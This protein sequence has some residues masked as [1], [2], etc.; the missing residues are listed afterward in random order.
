M[1]PIVD[2]MRSTYEIALPILLG[3]VIW[4]LQQQRNEISKDNEERKF[5]QK[6][7]HEIRKANAAGIML[8][9]RLKLIEYHSKYTRIGEI[10]SFAY[11]NFNDMYEVYH[12]LGGNGM[13]TKM[14]RELDELHFKK[15]EE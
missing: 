1:S 6:E 3:Y 10:P 14:K 5:Q 8:L 11:E 2:F 9:L 13:V 7:E 15:K 4:L 12:R